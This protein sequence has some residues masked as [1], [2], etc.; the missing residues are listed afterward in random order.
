MTFWC[1]HLNK[2]NY[3][4]ILI[5]ILILHEI[6]PRRNEEENVREHVDHTRPIH[7]RCRHLNSIRTFLLES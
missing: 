3:Y 2:R 6:S 5:L 7:V 1:S 4:T